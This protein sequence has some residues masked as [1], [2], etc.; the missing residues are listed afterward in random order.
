MNGEYIISADYEINGKT[1]RCL[2]QPAGY[3]MEQAE[4]VLDRMLNNPTKNDKALIK[5]G[6]NLGIEFLEAKHCWWN[7]GCD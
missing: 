3:T 7:Y 6:V 1:C 5:D 2:V 4:E